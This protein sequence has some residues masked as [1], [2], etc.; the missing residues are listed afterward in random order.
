MGRRTELEE[1]GSALNQ[2]VDRL[3]AIHAATVDSREARVIEIAVE[4]IQV[5]RRIVGDVADWAG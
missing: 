1:V 3:A 4:K 5:A 2:V